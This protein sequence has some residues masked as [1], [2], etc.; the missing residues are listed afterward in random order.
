MAELE[1]ADVVV[2]DVEVVVEVDTVTAG[3]TVQS[4]SPVGGLHI[5]LC[6]H[7]HSCSIEGSDAAGTVAMRLVAVAAVV[8]STPSSLVASLVS[9]ASFA[10][11]V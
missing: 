11:A 7:T 2:G 9:L 3:S 8:V 5:Y 6:H 1:S 10:V 4:H